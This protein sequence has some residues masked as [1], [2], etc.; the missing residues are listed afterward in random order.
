MQSQHSSIN[1]KW[2]VFLYFLTWLTVVGFRLDS[3]LPYEIIYALVLFPFQREVAL[4]SISQLGTMLWLG[5]E[6]AIPLMLILTCH[7]LGHYLQMRRYRVR[8]SLPY[9]IPMP[10]GPFGTLGAVIAMDGRIPNSRALF[11]I[12]ITGPLAG[13]VPTLICLYFGIQ[14]SYFG[15]YSGG[16]DAMFGTPLLFDYMN[17]WIFGQIPPD[18]VL[19]VHPVAMAGWVG[20]LLTSLNLLPFSQL[21]GGHIFYALLGRR[22]AFFSMIL[23]YAIIVIVI[24]NQFWHWSLILIILA[25]IGVSHPPTANDDMPLTPFRRILGWTTLAFVL[26]GLTPT[27]ITF[28]DTPPPQKLPKLYCQ[29]QIYSAPA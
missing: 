13:L 25:F 15:S 24:Y 23:F 1:W 10:I 12:G 11:D 14:W 16:A 8:S 7:E 20:L 19:Y 28:N 22:A 21:D 2:P 27:P 9:F 4:E 26:L 29:I 18:V 17:E 3:P 6:Y 5:L